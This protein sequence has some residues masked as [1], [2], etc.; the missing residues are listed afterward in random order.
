MPNSTED[1][2]RRRR[3]AAGGLDDPD[4]EG[5]RFI[6]GEA[7]LIVADRV[8]EERKAVE[9]ALAP[10]IQAAGAALRAGDYD[11][12]A[13]LYMSVAATVREKRF[14]GWADGWEARA[15]DCREAKKLAQKKAKKG[16][17]WK[18]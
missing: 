14:P 10:T 2:E 15:R 3:L 6:D 8:E 18:R 13:E 5:S 17:G 1:A 7:L 4:L 16:R 11:R 9:Q 12:A